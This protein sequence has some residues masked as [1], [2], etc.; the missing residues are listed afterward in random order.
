MDFAESACVKDAATGAR[1][2]MNGATS[3]TIFEDGVVLAKHAD[4]T[5]IRTC[6]HHVVVECPGLAAVEIDTDIDAHGDGP[7][8]G[9][10]SGRRQGRRTDSV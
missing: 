1:V 10:S 5:I 2:W 9:A 6:E 7:R 8:A 4:G 3:L